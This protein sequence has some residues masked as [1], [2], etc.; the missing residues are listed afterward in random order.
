MTQRLPFG[1]ALFALPFLA[2]AGLACWA[3]WTYHHPVVIS[4]MLIE[5]PLY[6]TAAWYC[7][8]HEDAATPRDRRW[9]VWLILGVALAIRLPLLFPPPVSTDI[10]R[11]VWDGKVQAAGINP[12]RYRPADPALAS[13]RD[14]VIFTDINRATTART[15]YPPVAQMVFFLATRIAA[16]VPVMKAVMVGFELLTV[17]ALL[18][19]L[20]RRGLPETRIL[21]YAWHPLPLFEFAGSGHVDAVAIACMLLATL[22]ADRRRPGLA[23]TLLGLAVAAKYFPAAIVPALWRRWDWRL[24]LAGLVVLVLCYLPYLGVGWQVLGFLPGYAKEEG[25]ASGGGF[26]LLALLRTVTSLPGFA[27]SLYIL[28]GCAGLL[29]AGIAVALRRTPREAALG[30]ALGL[31]LGFTLLFSPHLAWYFTWLVPFL[32]FRPSAALIYL[33]GAAP[34]L[35][36]MVWTPGP[37]A[38]NAALYLP[39]ALLLLVEIRAGA[40]RPVAVYP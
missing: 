9:A 12:Y 23:G 6:G 27:S 16:T 39:F 31:M 5:V 19:L 36:H 1:L 15:I 22:A 37:L 8:R 38:I 25:L 35:Y 21:L 14:T 17:A 34:L 33:T 13:L 3:L 20:R 10:F 32:C 26:F 4:I 40:W 29:A 24:P 18:A 28:L 7:L 11:Y 2:L 30:A